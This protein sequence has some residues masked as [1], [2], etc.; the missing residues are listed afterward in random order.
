MSYEKSYLWSWGVGWVSYAS[1]WAYG[2]IWSGW[3]WSLSY[4][5]YFGPR[6]GH[7][8]GEPMLMKCIGTFGFIVGRKENEYVTW[9]V[10]YE[11]CISYEI[12]KGNI[13]LCELISIYYCQWHMWSVKL[14]LMDSLMKYGKWVVYWNKNNEK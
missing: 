7:L 6:W 1:K 10:I 4:F 3:V 11:L 5:E 8:G 14:P 12:Y 2:S 9:E 13:K